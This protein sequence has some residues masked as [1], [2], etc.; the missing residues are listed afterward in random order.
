MTQ[1]LEHRVEQ[2]ETK[3]AH[4]ERSIVDAQ[5]SADKRR[6]REKW[7]RIALL[8]VLALAY[9]SYLEQALS[10]GGF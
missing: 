5:T 3:L 9:W 2:L 1:D 8:L 4:L 10:I 6:T 7:I